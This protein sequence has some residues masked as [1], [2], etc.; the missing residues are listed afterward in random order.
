[1][2]E[3]EGGERAGLEGAVPKVGFEYRA[4]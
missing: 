1:M 2:V 4:G 3:S